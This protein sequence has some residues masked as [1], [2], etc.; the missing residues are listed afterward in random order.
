LPSA[1]ARTHLRLVKLTHALISN[2]VLFAEQIAVEAIENIRTVAT[3]TQEEKLHNDF[4]R[5]IKVPYE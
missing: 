4:N 1:I 5:L 2:S 3:L